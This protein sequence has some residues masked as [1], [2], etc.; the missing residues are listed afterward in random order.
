[1]TITDGLKDLLQSRGAAMVGFASLDD[2]PSEARYGMPI[3]ISIAV[4]LNPMVIAGIQSGPTKQYCTEYESANNLLSS[5]GTIAV[6]FLHENHYEAKLLAPTT[7][8]FNTTTLSTALPHKTVATLAGLGW[9]GKCALLITRSFGSAIRLTTVLTNAEV[10]IGDAVNV[11]RCGSCSDCVEVCPGHASSG[12]NWQ[13]GLQR[14]SFFNAHACRQTA[15]EMAEKKAGTTHT[16]CGMCIAVCPWTLKY[17]RT[18]VTHH[19]LQS[20]T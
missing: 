13:S 11:S 8:D 3:G 7:E 1:M 4:A 5:L 6:N 10:T 19:H 18:S 2:L 16:I 15:K 12:K 20:G 9:I 14:D 17:S